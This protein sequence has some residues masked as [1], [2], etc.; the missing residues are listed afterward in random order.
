MRKLRSG[1]EVVIVD[2]PTLVLRAPKPK[3]QVVIVGIEFDLYARTNRRRQKKSKPNH[4]YHHY[5]HYT[6]VLKKK[7]SSFF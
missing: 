3:P 5:H 1:D 2:I 7:N 4:H 6:T